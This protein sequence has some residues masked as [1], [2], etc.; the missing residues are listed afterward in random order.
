MAGP[1]GLV[2]GPTGELTGDVDLRERR[3]LY[4]GFGNAYTRAFEFVLTPLLFAAVGW[5]LDTWLGTGPLLVLLL[6]LFALV[7]MTTRA[8]YQYT[9][10]M[11]AHLAA[12][13][14]HRPSSA[15]PEPEPA[16]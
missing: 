15:R 7:G 9:V 8:W 3:H 14:G 1:G 11:D 13:P 6:G 5:G 10:E 2:R 4:N 16:T 12:L